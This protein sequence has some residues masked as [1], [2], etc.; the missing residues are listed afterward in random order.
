MFGVPEPRL[1]RQAPEPVERVSFADDG[2]RGKGR[3]EATGFDPSKSMATR[4]E[5]LVAPTRCGLSNEGLSSL[6]VRQF[7][8]VL[9]H[10]K[11]IGESKGDTKTS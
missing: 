7:P 5:G 2:Q 4:S 11:G 3:Q 8:R 9:R 1:G 6:W 10:F